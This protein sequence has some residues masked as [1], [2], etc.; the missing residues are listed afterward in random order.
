MAE[1]SLLK[2]KKISDRE[3]E[4]RQA[5]RRTPEWSG[6]RTAAYTFSI[7]RSTGQ[8]TGPRSAAFGPIFRFMRTPERES[9]A[10]MR[11]RFT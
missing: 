3:G 8:P 7:R 2:R 4:L 5:A 9:I 11:Q 10:R 1:R 6:A